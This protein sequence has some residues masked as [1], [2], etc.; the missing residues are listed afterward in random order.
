LRLAHPYLAI[1][2]S[3]VVVSELIPVLALVAL[4]LALVDPLATSRPVFAGLSVEQ[5]LVGMIVWADSEGAEE[6]RKKVDV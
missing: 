1:T 2:C 3:P 4:V 6:E 5:A